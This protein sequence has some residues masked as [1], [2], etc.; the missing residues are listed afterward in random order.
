MP[1][2][3]LFRYVTTLEARIKAL[4]RQLRGKGSEQAVT[5]DRPDF[6]PG[7]SDLSHL[8]QPASERVGGI[9]HAEQIS[10]QEGKRLE[11][12]R[13]PLHRGSRGTPSSQCSSQQGQLPEV[14]G[15]LRGQQPWKSDIT[16]LG[17]LHSR[18]FTSDRDS[19]ALP[20]LPSNDRARELVDAVYFY[21]QAR[22]CIIDWIQLREWHRD[23]EAIAYTST[24]GSTESQTGNKPET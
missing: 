24:E 18:T 5:R 7:A 9:R 6:T 3:T 11:N 22:Y 19:E 15:E 10:D 17:M 14:L 21:T 4:E 20:A 23:R 16:F 1:V 13:S 8:D 2:F 12:M